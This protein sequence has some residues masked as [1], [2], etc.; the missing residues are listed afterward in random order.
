MPTAA[1]GVLVTD[2]SVRHSVMQSHTLPIDSGPKFRLSISHISV[3]PVTLCTFVFPSTQITKTVFST[4]EVGVTRA[5]NC[6]DLRSG[7]NLVQVREIAGCATPTWTSTRPEAFPLPKDK[8][9]WELRPSKPS[10][11]MHS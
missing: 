2:P 6:G 3:E 4:R 7:E 1:D 9:P 5:T 11:T 10:R 8:L